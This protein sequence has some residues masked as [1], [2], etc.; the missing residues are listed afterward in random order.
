MSNEDEPV[1]LIAS[2]LTLIGAD[3]RRTILTP[4][5]FTVDG[6]PGRGLISAEFTEDGAALVTLVSADGQQWAKLRA[7]DDGTG[8]YFACPDGG[9]SLVARGLSVIGP[10]EKMTLTEHGI[11]VKSVSDNS[12]LFALPFFS[13]ADVKQ[14]C[15]GLGGRLKAALSALIAPTE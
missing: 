3:G 6:G 5:G 13:I 9:S 8:L 7:G 11:E 2:Q 1:D 10:A 12:K 4:G 14:L 15:R